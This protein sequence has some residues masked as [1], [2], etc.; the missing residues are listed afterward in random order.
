MRDP[1]DGES[2]N[3]LNRLIIQS[4]RDFPSCLVFLIDSQ[5][6]CVQCQLYR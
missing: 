5:W 1:Y 2:W 4:E 6:G 3:A